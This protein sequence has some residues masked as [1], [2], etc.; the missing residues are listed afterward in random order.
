[1]RA[2][3]DDIVP[4]VAFVGRIDLVAIADRFDV[5]LAVPLSSGSNETCPTA[6][7]S[8]G[9]SP[10]LAN[11][12]LCAARALL[13]QN[14]HAAGLLAASTTLQVLLATDE[15]SQEGG[16]SAVALIGDLRQ[17][18]GHIAQ[19]VSEQ[20]PP[21]VP[22]SRPLIDGTATR[23]RTLKKAVSDLDELLDEIDEVLETDAEAFVKSYVQKG[24]Q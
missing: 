14:P 6:L 17:C 8:M 23:T 15:P 7:A 3:I 2:A 13:R 10:A 22:E 16:D 1:M 24:G 20:A 4:K 21:S 12:Q 11:S 19:R 18:A 9:L 5:L